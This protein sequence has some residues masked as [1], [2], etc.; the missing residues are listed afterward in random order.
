MCRDIDSRLSVSWQWVT[1]LCVTTFGHVSMCHDNGSHLCVSRTLGHVYWY[2]R[3]FYYTS[4]FLGADC[5]MKGS[6]HILLRSPWKQYKIQCQK[7]S[8][9]SKGLLYTGQHH[10][11]IPLIIN[12][13]ATFRGMHVS[14]AK[15]CYAWLPRKC[16][17]QTDR[18]TDRQ[19]DRR[20]TKWSLCAAMLR[21]RH[22]NLYSDDSDTL[23]KACFE[24]KC[25]DLW[26]FHSSN[27]N[28]MCK[29]DIKGFSYCRF[30][31]RQ[32]QRRNAR[33]FVIC[34]FFWKLE[35]IFINT[36]ITANGLF[37]YNL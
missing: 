14:P 1:F 28:V 22:K 7:Q 21:R 11:N 35:N 37:Y 26:I 27:I 13:V 25:P 23:N 9:L 8:G 17:N 12:I 33:P 5:A 15:H 32:W 31:S 36:I 20:R 16:D 19:T 34:I 2:N 4:R 6:C 3:T 29:Y 30:K 10:I 24:N 18:H